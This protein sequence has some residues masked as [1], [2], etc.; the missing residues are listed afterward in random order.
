MI[1][2]ACA[3]PSPELLAK[4]LSED[5][6]ARAPAYVTE[7][8]KDESTS[9]LTTRGQSAHWPGQKAN[10]EHTLSDCATN[11]ETQRQGA[12]VNVRWIPAHEGIDENEAGD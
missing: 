5:F 1:K 10:R 4:A 2:D 12:V 3:Y 7:A 6:S 8:A 11:H 9:L